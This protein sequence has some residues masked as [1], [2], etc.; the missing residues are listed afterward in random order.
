MM[1]LQ[2]GISHGIGGDEG[3]A[4]YCNN[5]TSNCDSLA[6]V[7]RGTWIYVHVTG[8]IERTSATMHFLSDG[9]SWNWETNEV[10][11]RADKVPCAPLTNVEGSDTVFN[12]GVNNDYRRIALAASR[13]PAGAVVSNSHGKPM[14]AAPVYVDFATTPETIAMCDASGNY[15]SFSNMLTTQGFVASKGWKPNLTHPEIDW[16]PDLHDD[17]AIVDMGGV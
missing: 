11:F 15:Q 6:D 1:H 8:D 9:D 12:S 4:L 13:L 16:G 14:D 5:L 10:A 17:E 3:A 7:G 2:D